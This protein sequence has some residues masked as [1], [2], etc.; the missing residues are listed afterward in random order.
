MMAE[1]VSGAMPVSGTFRSNTNLSVF[2][3]EWDDCCEK[4]ICIENSC[5]SLEWRSST[6]AAVRQRCQS[7]YPQWRNYVDLFTVTDPWKTEKLLNAMRNCTLGILPESLWTSGILCPGSNSTTSLFTARWVSLEEPFPDW[8]TPEAVTLGTLPE[9]VDLQCTFLILFTSMN[10]TSIQYDFQPQNSRHAAICE[11]R[12]FEPVVTSTQSES[13]HWSEISETTHQEKESTSPV[14]ATFVPKTLG[15]AEWKQNWSEDILPTSFSSSSSQQTT[16][17]RTIATS[18]EQNRVCRGKEAAGINWPDTPANAVVNMSCPLGMTGYAYW[19]CNGTNL[20]FTPEM[21]TIIHC[22]HT[23][24]KELEDDMEGGDDA[25]KIST[26]LAED[27]RNKSLSHGDVAALVNLS[28]KLLRLYVV[29]KGE[30]ELETTETDK[31]PVRYA[32]TKSMI[33]AM[34]NILREPVKK[35][36]EN[37]SKSHQTEVAAK[38]LNVVSRIGNRLSCVKKSSDKLQ[39]TVASENIAL[40]TFILNSSQSEANEGSFITFPQQINNMTVNDLISVPEDMTMRSRFPSCRNYNS[41]YG[42]LYNHVGDFL[43][44]ELSE[45]NSWSQI[46]SRVISFSV[47]NDTD[48]VPLPSNQYV[49]FT[50]EHVLQGDALLSLTPRCVFWNFS[51]EPYGQWD[52][53]GCFVVN[54]NASHTVCKCNHLTNFAVLMDVNDNVKDDTVLSLMTYIC[55]GVS[56]LALFLTL[57]CFIAIRPLRDRR[58]IITGNL[59]FSLLNTNL[60]ILFGL[61]QTKNKIVCACIAGLLQFWL[62][63]AFCWM[64]LEGYHLYRMIILVFQRSADFSVKVY[65]FFAYGVSLLVVGISAGLRYDDYVG[66]K[67]CWLSSKNGLIWSFVGPACCII[68]ANLAIFILTLRSASSVRIKREKTGVENVK[69]WVKGSLS[70][71]CLLGLTWCLG[72]FYIDQKLGFFSYIFTVFNGL[73]GVFIFL[74]HILLNEKFLSWICNWSKLRCRKTSLNQTLSNHLNSKT[75]TRSINSL[76]G[77]KPKTT[78]SIMPARKKDDS[79]RDLHHCNLSNRNKTAQ[80]SPE[81]TWPEDTTSRMRIRFQ[82]LSHG[83]ANPAFSY[84]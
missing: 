79:R 78:S 68:L 32:F 19:F 84:T 21:P 35:A 71:M 18:T 9:V 13:S 14:P 74:F 82:P 77:S 44:D 57:V 56:S 65:Y 31:V 76:Q 25:V 42:I 3:T 12:H 40:Q 63:S 39:F 72:L 75:S 41:A 23:W 52:S 28:A 48:S 16:T 10:A 26:K 33:S 66:D 61:D 11:F 7:K 58:G 67:Y 83:N 49:S 81:E 46:A 24:I 70:I 29:Q 64:L 59:C 60:L 51:K 1:F 69:S 38:I 80:S 73:Q 5:Y 22:K 36:W 17:D 62:L 20:Q 55:C 53:N 37:L 34:S 8:L 50:L 15:P 30:E 4:N 54:W 43:K 6:W 27:T 2:K 45:R 47:S